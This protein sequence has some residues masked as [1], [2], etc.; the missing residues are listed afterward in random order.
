MPSRGV[1][2]WLLLLVM[3]LIVAIGADYIL[4][5]YRQRHGD[6]LSFS[7]VRKY[8]A[9]PDRNGRYHYEYFGTMDVPCV[10]AFLPHQR[11]T[12][13]WWVSLHEDHWL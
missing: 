13:C 8:Q 9:V 5:L 3:L 11:M 10:E 12:P 4:F 2:A 6:V 1:A 7:T